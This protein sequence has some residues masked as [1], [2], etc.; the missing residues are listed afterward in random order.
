MLISLLFLIPSSDRMVLAVVVLAVATVV[1]L[2]IFDVVCHVTK[3]KGVL[4]KVVR[5][6]NRHK[7]YGKCKY[8]VP[9][10]GGG[11]DFVPNKIF[12]MFPCSLK[13]FLQFW[14]SLFPKICFCCRVPSFIVFFGPLFPKSKWPCSLVPQNPWEALHPVALR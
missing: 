11:G 10:R 12:F 1:F 7:K 3:N 14:C 4:N 5:H 8:A 13:V 6:R 2:I 9:N